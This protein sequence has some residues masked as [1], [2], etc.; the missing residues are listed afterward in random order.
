MII[1]NGWIQLVDFRMDEVGVGKFP[2]GD[3]NFEEVVFCEENRVI[4]F[5][6]GGFPERCGNCDGGI[7]LWVWERSLPRP[8]I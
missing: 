4:G 8:R 1:R 7:R 3:F 5:V 6:G 2:R